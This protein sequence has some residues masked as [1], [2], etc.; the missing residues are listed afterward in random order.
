MNKLGKFIFILITVGVSIY[1]LMPTIQWYF[2]IP[3]KD[4]QILNLSQD[5]LDVQ[6][7][8][9]K[10][11]VVELKKVRKRSLSLGLDLQGGVNITLQISESEL[12]NQL[13]Q[14]YEFDQNKVD[15]IFKEEYASAV[16]RALEVL[17]NRM[18]QFGVSEP[19]IRKTF[20]NRISVELPGLD[21]PQLI[22]E[23][24]AKVGKLE[25]HIVDEK[26]MKSLQEL[27]VP[28]GSGGYVLSGS[29]LPAGYEIPMMGTNGE[30]I[31]AKGE[32]IPD[33]SEWVSYW[34]NDDFGMPKMKGWYV[35]EKKIELDGTM[36]K[37]GR[38][39]SDQYGKPK[40]DFEM[41]SEGAD[42]FA[43][44]TAQNI[45]KR[46]AIVLDNKVKSA[47]NIRSEISGGRGEI[48]GD[49]SL[50]ETVF[51]ANVLKAGALPVK[52]DIVQE[53]VIGPTL[54]RDSIL[55]SSRAL[56][57]GVLA[58]V[59][60][61]IIYYKIS[62]G[63]AIIGLGFNLLYLVAL[64]AGVSATL[65]LSGIAGI[66]LTIGMAV[67][68]NVI[69]YERI[70][71]EMRRS[72]GIKHAIHSGFEHA[73][74]TIWDSN[75]TTLI[76]AVAL[77]FF[78]EGTIKGFGLTLTFGIIANMFSSLFISRLIFDWWMDTFNPH[79]ISI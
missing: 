48:T 46:L 42:I 32:K 75:I 68:A 19:S 52:L 22:K 37:N 47:P 2:F 29:E 71:E 5:Q 41:T 38:S 51:L 63:I 20:D 9:I 50:E 28:M 70:R 44:V 26:T 54:G 8:E 31:R 33:T 15:S 58:V 62:G 74:A 67:D 11:K 60:F 27:N 45:N 39:D 24:L 12:S 61:M 23:A 16:D 66:A 17:R 43:E 57:Y 64:L 21:N 3:E 7:S 69:I 59:L 77:Y 14:K 1:F 78:G 4:K 73:S 76:A 6:S 79:K 53:R 72:R 36:V 34:E 10:K 65:T 40:I 56:L 25:F 30:T 49:F 18:D 35:L 13:L 55:Q